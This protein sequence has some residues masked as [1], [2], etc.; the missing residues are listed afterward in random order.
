MEKKP[1]IIMDHL[2]NKRINNIWTL[3]EIKKEE[4]KEKKHIMAE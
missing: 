2:K 4:R 1:K 3:F